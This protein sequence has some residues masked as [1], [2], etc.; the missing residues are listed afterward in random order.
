MSR[1]MALWQSVP[2]QMG[3][4]EII[5]RQRGGRRKKAG[6]KP[7]G[8]RKQV[9]HKAR[10]Q[11]RQTHRGACVIAR[12]AA[13]LESAQPA[14][15]RRDREVPRRRAGAVRV[16]IIEFSVLGNHLHL[17]VE[18][19]SS[20]ALSRGMQ[21]LTVR[22]AKA[23]NRA[24]GGAAR[25]SPITTIRSC[26]ARRPG[27]PTRS[28][29]CSATPHTT[30]VAHPSTI[31]SRPQFMSLRAGNASS[32]AREGGCSCTDGGARL[33]CLRGSRRCY[34]SGPLENSARNP[35]NTRSRAASSVRVPDSASLDRSNVGA[36]PR[37]TCFSERAHTPDARSRAARLLTPSR[38]S[39]SPPAP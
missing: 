13:R 27:W 8:P 32:R 24:C 34:C 39:A 3:Q 1:G 17:I 36:E 37:N 38:C 2:I 4:L 10:P 16:R 14:V 33:G 20:V 31:R 26:C 9:S 11:I 19:D 12:G 29:T 23:L 15:L 35:A 5:W 21:G 22:I 28:R 30:M 6:R 18:A 7:N 25:C